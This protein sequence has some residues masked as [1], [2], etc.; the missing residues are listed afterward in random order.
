MP[1]KIA[2]GAGQPLVG[3]PAETE[4]IFLI[5]ISIDSWCGNIANAKLFQTAANQPLQI[6][7]KMV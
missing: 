2:A 5:G 3:I 4:I 7:L 1:A 6:K